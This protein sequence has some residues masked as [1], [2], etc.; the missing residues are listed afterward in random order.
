MNQQH[1]VSA[2]HITKAYTGHLALD[3]VT[4]TIPTG[5]ITGLLGPN[6]AG[7]T[8]FIRILNQIIA[9]DAGSI[10]LFGEPLEPKHIAAIGYLPEERGLYKK[11]KVGEQ[12]LY[13]AQLRGLSKKDAMSRIRHW[14]ERF[15]I[16]PWWSKK[17][18]DLSKGMAQKVQ[19]ISTV[20][21]GPKLLI[22]DEPF[23]GFDPV[24]AKLLTE[25][26]L[27]LRDQGATVIFSTHRMETVESLCDHVVMINRSKKI[28]E[29]TRESVISGY[30]SGTFEV[31]HRT[32]GITL[33]AD[34]FTL[35]STTENPGGGLRSVV[36]MHDG[37]TGN[38]LLQELI[39][40]TEIS[41]F[42]EKLPS[43]ADIFISLVQGEEDEQLKKH[44]GLNQE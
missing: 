2:E 12:L 32:G 30:R 26:I 16:K 22:L 41:G 10:R 1:A 17:V 11:M 39:G 19:F 34:L 21:H 3:D 6:G 38:R 14:F 25:V 7:K 5:S 23:S 33:P 13:L 40:Q 15:D 4:I 24:N 27:E 44:I 8:T 29:G 28:L 20:L 37:G 18:E 31:D 36:R 35:V 9:A 43:M 42:R